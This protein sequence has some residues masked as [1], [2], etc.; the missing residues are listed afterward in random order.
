MAGEW[1]YLR[2]W[3]VTRTV[4]PTRSV[5]FVFY[6]LLGPFLFGGLQIWV[7]ILK[8]WHSGMRPEYSGLITAISTFFPALAGSTALQLV[9]FIT[10]P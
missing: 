6:V 5:P 8:W 1:G 3:L 7:E 2:N 4:E 9:F 10:A